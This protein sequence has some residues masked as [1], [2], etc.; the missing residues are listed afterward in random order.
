MNFPNSSFLSV[1]KIVYL[2]HF[3]YLYCNVIPKSPQK[4]PTAPPP[5]STSPICSALRKPRRTTLCLQVAG[6]ILDYRA[7]NGIKSI[8]AAKRRII[9]LCQG[10]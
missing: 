10:I 1:K 7:S 5:Q 8:S 6:R 3:Q 9:S 4:P 2:S